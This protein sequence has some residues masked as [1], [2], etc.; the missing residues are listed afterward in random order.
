MYHHFRGTLVKSNPT[1]AVIEAG[2]V[3]Y[4][5]TIS[6]STSEQLP[7]VG[8]ECML[9]AHY[10]VS[11]NSQTLFGFA[12]ET[13]RTLFRALISIKGVGPSTA[14][15]IL[16]G[17]TPDVFVNAVETQDHMALK[18]IKGI[19][20]K[21]AKRIILELK[22]SSA[23]STFERTGSTTNAS[24]TPAGKGNIK[25]SAAMALE[26]LGISPKEAEARVEKVVG[27]SDNL[28]LEEII[29]QALQ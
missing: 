2:G 29:R 24:F 17:T 6:I 12:T 20:E 8:S 21:T 14:I 11:E 10:S 16:S 28:E 5:L 13:E 4:L 15:Q 23:F 22:D 25:K 26:A 9:L 19:G 27:S 18:K 3:G 1:T 7:A